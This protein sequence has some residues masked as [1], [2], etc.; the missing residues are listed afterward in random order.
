VDHR[1]TQIFRTG[2]PPRL[3]YRDVVSGTVVL[4]NHWVIH[5]DICRPLIEV[6]ERVATRG[7]YIAQQLVGCHHRTGGAVNEACL[8]FPPGRQEACAIT[9]RKR[10]DAKPVDALG[11]LF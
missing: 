7:H 11:S 9:G 4:K 2:L 1:L 3:P 8:D 5:G 10:P 6:T